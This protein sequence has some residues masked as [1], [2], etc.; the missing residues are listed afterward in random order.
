MI[1]WAGV[2]GALAG[3][4]VAEFDTVGLML[5]ALLGALAGLG[6]RSAVRKE[7]ARAIDAAN[8]PVVARYLPPTTTIAL[9]L[10]PQTVFCSALGY[11]A[12]F[13]KVSVPDL[14]WLAHF[15]HRVDEAGLPCAA[16]GECSATLTPQA[17][18][19]ANPSLALVPVRVV[20]S[21][22]LILDPTARTCTRRLVEKVTIELSDRVLRHTVEDQPVDWP[23]E[24]CAALSGA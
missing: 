17:L 8:A 19:S 11:S 2:C 3:W 20:L 18:L 21:E 6:L 7:I 10:S 9:A 1:L 23:Y 24:T 22:S 5:G 16:A 13:L 4:V 12:S 14:D 15:D